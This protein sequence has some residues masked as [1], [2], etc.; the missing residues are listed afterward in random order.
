[1]V[2][3]ADATDLPLA[4]A[5]FTTSIVLVILVAGVQLIPKEYNEAAEVFGAG[6]WTRFRR[7]TLP[8]IRPAILSA[9]V[10]RGRTGQGQ[11]LDV[12]MLDATA[13]KGVK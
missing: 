10:R 2:A 9:L 13:Q 7:I 1:M 5:P 12:A 3:A 6:P 4:L 8:L 11:H